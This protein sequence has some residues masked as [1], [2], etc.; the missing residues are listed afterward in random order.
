MVRIFLLFT[1]LIIMAAFTISAFWLELNGEATIDILNRLP[2]LFSPANYVY[3]LWFVIFASLFVWNVK[4]YKNRHTSLRIST[5]QTGLFVG[6]SLLQ[7]AFLFIWHHELYIS[8]LIFLVLQ[9]LSLFGLYKTYPLNEEGIQL[10]IPI[11][12][13]LGWSLFLFF[14]LI[15]YTLVFFEWPGFGLSNALW[16]VILMTIGTASTLHLRYHYSD[17]ISPLVFIWGYLGITFT[18]SFEEL[19][20]STAALF[21]CGVMVAGILFMK[22]NH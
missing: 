15:S 18:N 7:V 12:A 19:L 4:H 11:A 14:A 2:L 1:S 13:F 21:L 16:A 8:A 17:I 3:L 5:L 10:R 6:I 20:V 9:L 22:K